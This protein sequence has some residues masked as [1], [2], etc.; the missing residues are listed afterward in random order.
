MDMQAAT[1]PGR[2][3]GAAFESIG[4]TVGDTLEKFRA[5]K[6]KKKQ[7]K[8]LGDTVFNQFKDNPEALG[9]NGEDELRA[10]TNSLGKN[11]DALNFVT[12]FRRDAQ[13][14]KNYDQIMEQR[15]MLIDSLGDKKD[16]EEGL[17]R[18]MVGPP[19]PKAIPSG[20]TNLDGRQ[21]PTLPGKFASN[22]YP[23]QIAGS[24][25]GRHLPQTLYPQR[26]VPEQGFKPTGPSINVV[27]GEV[28]APTPPIA[29]PLPERFQAL[30]NSDLSPE[31]K[32]QGIAE[33]KAEAMVQQKFALEQQ[34]AGM[35]LTPG[36]T[37]FD[38]TFAKSLV[39]FNEPDVR[40]GM[41]QLRGAINS[42][43]NSDTLSGPF[44]SLLPNFFGDRVNPDAAQTREAIEEVVQRNLRLVLGAQFTEREGERLISRAYNPRLEE[45]QNIERVQRLFKSIEDAMNA[46]LRQKAYFQRYGT[47]KGHTGLEAEAAFWGSLGDSP[48]PASGQPSAEGATPEDIEAL[49]QQI[50]SKTAL[51]VERAATLE[52]FF[53]DPPVGSEPAGVRDQRLDDFFKQPPGSQ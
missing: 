46:K 52:G 12:Q 3:W 23:W 38:Q 7:Q 43:E 39:E 28:T 26:R 11:P 44:V 33:M 18:F 20:E 27:T 41:E 32:A 51:E 40:K 13:I 35:S 22:P 21:I 24:A 25:F 2:N 16:R 42:L 6:E 1:A 48:S 53:A 17:A 5:D 50:E 31:A 10:I 47:L 37:S 19:K 45:E 36:E 49:R 9:A 15:G 30:L 4:Q 8:I 34:K 14:A 29:Q